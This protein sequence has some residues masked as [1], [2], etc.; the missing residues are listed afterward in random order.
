MIRAIYPGTFDPITNGHIDIIERACKLFDELVV[1]VLIN[2]NKKP[3]FSA[4]ERLEIL[5]EVLEPYAGKIKIDTFEGLLV[6][7][8]HKHGA[9]AIVRGIRSVNDYEYEMPMIL[10]NRRLNPEVETVL[11]T[12]SKDLSM[13]SSSLI[14]EVFSLGGSIDGLVP[15]VVIEKMRKK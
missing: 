4:E 2:P 7:F 8:A 3:F 9:S 6:D 13:I 15:N 11:L 1:A 5:H 14:K 12:A 10:M